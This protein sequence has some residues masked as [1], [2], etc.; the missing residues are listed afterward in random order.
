[1]FVPFFYQLRDAQIPVS[2]TAFLTLQR[3]LK[4]GLVTSLADFYTAARS[5]LIKSER[6]F[7][8]FD[9]IFAHHFEGLHFG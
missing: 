8:R 6:Y 2:P 3:A 1:M 4:R 5:I 9:Q 7:D